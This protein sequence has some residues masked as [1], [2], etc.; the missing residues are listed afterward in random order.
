MA[1]DKVNKVI[2]EFYGCFWHGCRKCHP[3]EIAKYDSTMERKNMLEEA[4][5][6]V[7]VIW[8]CEWNEEKATLPN[9]KELRRTS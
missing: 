5:Y 6:K 2:K 4:G 9:R 7:E 1:T 8:E 3:E